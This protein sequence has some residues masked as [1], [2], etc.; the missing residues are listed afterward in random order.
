MGLFT[1]APENLKMS[2]TISQPQ[3]P[4]FKSWNASY[5][6][7]LKAYWAVVLVLNTAHFAFQVLLVLQFGALWVLWRCLFRRENDSLRELLLT[8]QHC[9]RKHKSKTEAR[10]SHTILWHFTPYPYIIIAFLPIR[11]CGLKNPHPSYSDPSTQ[12]SFTDINCCRLAVVF[13][14]V[15]RGIY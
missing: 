10:V 12:S 4:Q 5:L 3:C 11:S 8:R 9:P 15:K 14:S 2:C 1:E 13:V 6:T 7:T